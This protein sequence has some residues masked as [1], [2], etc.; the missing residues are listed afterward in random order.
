[1][2]IQAY[3]SRVTPTTWR[4]FL[5]A[6]T[7][8]AVIEEQ[9]RQEA[10]HANSRPNDDLA[11]VAEL[12]VSKC[13]AC[14]R[15]M[16]DDFDG[17]LALQCGCTIA[18]GAGLG[19]GQNLCAYCFQQCA[20]ETA[21]HDHLSSCIWNP[22]PNSMFPRQDHRE[23]LQQVR[24][25]RVWY[26]V[27]ATVVLQ[28]QI[29]AIWTKIAGVYPE[30]GITHEWLEER[31]AWLTIASEMQISFDDFAPLAPKYERCLL[32]VI[33]MGFGSRE[34]AMRA[35]LLTKGDPSQAVLALLASSATQ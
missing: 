35:T 22:R 15:L 20:D 9:N 26:H 29:P 7:E 24:R 6:V 5:D 10:L 17:C 13:P 8:S 11:F 34:S 14:S 4:A 27:V 33:D 12:I 3:S 25:Q 21:V 16:A 31:D 23:I 1:M 18:G 2:N 30:L 32:S 19:C 28:Q